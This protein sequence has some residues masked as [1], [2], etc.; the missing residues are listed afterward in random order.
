VSRHAGLPQAVPGRR[1]TFGGV[2]LAS[3]IFP[4]HE[5]RPRAQC[6]RTRA[7]G[8][9]L[10]PYSPKASAAR[11]S[12]HIV[13]RATA[14]GPSG[15]DAT[16]ARLRSARSSSS[17]RTLSTPTRMVRRA[18]PGQRGREKIKFACGASRPLPHCPVKRS[19]LVTSSCDPEGHGRKG[20]SPVETICSINS[21]PGSTTAR[22]TFFS[23]R[24]YEARTTPKAR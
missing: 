4:H 6:R 23:P 16:A 9:L 7:L 11:P 24:E 19:R 21:M 3:W 15:P 10:D 14:P 5:G 8:C 20:T 17:T 12:R 22:R 13:G 18:H 1:R 2:P